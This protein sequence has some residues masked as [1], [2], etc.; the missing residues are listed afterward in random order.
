L[1][2]DQ[3]LP[4]QIISVNNR[5]IEE[6][7]E[8][9][10]VV[11]AVFLDFVAIDIE[12]CTS[13]GND[14][15]TTVVEFKDLSHNDIMRFRRIFDSLVA[16]L[17]KAD[18]RL[19]NIRMTL[20]GAWL[21]PIDDDFLF[22]DDND[23]DDDGWATRV[24]SMWNDISSSNMQLREEGFQ[25]LARWAASTPASHQEIA[26]GFANFQFGA[27]IFADPKSSLAGMYPAASA[28]RNVSC[29]MCTDACDVLASAPSFTMLEKLEVS[30]L[31][32]LV[33]Q[34]LTMA[35]KGMRLWKAYSL[36]CPAK[37]TASSNQCSASTRCTDT[38]DLAPVW[39]SEQALSE[40]ED[41]DEDEYD[42]GCYDAPSL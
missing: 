25:H 18:L 8:F 37:A 42:D 5:D 23:G 16:F 3:S 35:M 20:T 9:H 4:A 11:A 10:P 28:L 27:S 39:T 40:D 13:A 29:G 15:N 34:E 19:A 38:S 21:R 7:E 31:P 2:L 22:D 14:L 26:R 33:A 24:K 30:E 6:N 41:E 1:F 12:V 17:Q 32:P 36:K